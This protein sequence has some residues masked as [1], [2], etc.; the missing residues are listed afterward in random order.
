MID[1]KNG[2]M[3]EKWIFDSDLYLPSNKSTSKKYH[4]TTIFD[5]P[6]AFNVLSKLWLIFSL[7]SV[8]FCML[9]FK[10]FFFFGKFIFIFLINYYKKI[11]HL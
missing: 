8:F 10:F 7:S 11:L 1:E 5:I 6:F 3:V 4:I 2:V 9:L